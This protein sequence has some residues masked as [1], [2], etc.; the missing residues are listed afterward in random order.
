MNDDKNER[1]KGIKGFFS[2]LKSVKNIELIVCII[3][4]AIILLLYG[5]VR[6]A[7]KKEDGSAGE[8]SLTGT[9]SE[10]ED[11]CGKLEK[12]LSEIKGAGN[13]RVYI[14]YESTGEVVYV[15]DRTVNTTVRE[16]D[17][18]GANLKTT[19]TE[20]KTTPVFTG[21]GSSKNPLVEK[22]KGPKIQGVVIVAEGA[23]DIKVRLELM[24]ATAAALNIDEKI[25]KIFIMK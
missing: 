25:I 2:K 5:I 4:I 15:Y 22:T 17:S 11:E 7:K 24:E 23:A 10:G 16:D 21:E 6:E 1:G 14:G 8:T 18:G 20:E 3:L 9:L 13:V 12:I 19:V